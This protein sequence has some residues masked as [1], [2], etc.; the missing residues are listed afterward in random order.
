ME[1]TKNGRHTSPYRMKRACVSVEV[2]LQLKP[3]EPGGKRAR[4]AHSRQRGRTV[5]S[6]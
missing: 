6:L 3:E 5:Q 2:T 4:E 1:N